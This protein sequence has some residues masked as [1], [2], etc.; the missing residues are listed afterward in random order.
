MKKTIITI[1]TILFIA[2]IISCNC[3]N[4]TSQTTN[5]IATGWKN[6]DSGVELGGGLE[7]IG[8]AGTLQPNNVV[9]QRYGV[10]AEVEYANGGDETPLGILLYDVREFDENGERLKFNPQKAAELNAAISGQAV[11]IAT[12]GIFLFATGAFT[13]AGSVG[14][15]SSLYASGDGKLTSTAAENTKVGKAIGDP[16]ADGSVLVKL[17]L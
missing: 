4:N 10:N 1:F 11:P 5:E 6:Y 8:G 12:R 9:S 15:G 13:A 2:T 16:D 7:Y 14:A 3:A 17:E